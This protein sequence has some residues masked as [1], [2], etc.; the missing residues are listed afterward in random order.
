MRKLSTL[1]A[2]WFL[3]MAP[4]RAG[5]SLDYARTI[6]DQT[7]TIFGDNQ[8]QVGHTL[9]CHLCGESQGHRRVPPVLTR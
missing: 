6:L 5:T 8:N 4:A 7:R 3:S 9:N 1:L 2:V